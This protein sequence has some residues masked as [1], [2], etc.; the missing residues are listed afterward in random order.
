MAFVLGD[1]IRAEM[2]KRGEKPVEDEHWIGENESH[3]ASDKALYV[4]SKAANRVAR[5]PFV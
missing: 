4:Y 3:C 5:L 2:D 1:G